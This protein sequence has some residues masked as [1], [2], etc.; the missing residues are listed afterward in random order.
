MFSQKMKRKPFLFN[1]SS[2]AAASKGRLV[3][4]RQK[5]WG[6]EKWE[7]EKKWKK[8]VSEATSTENEKGGS[9]YRCFRRLFVT[10]IMALK[11]LAK[12]F[13]C[14]HSGILLK[15]LS[16][17]RSYR[18]LIVLHTQPKSDEDWSNILFTQKVFW[19]YS[20]VASCGYLQQLTLGAK[21]DSC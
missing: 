10:G 13:C 11:K 2:S 9:C 15:F 8:V 17:F 4:K 12:D 1:K 20:H 16:F 6:R 7:A 14:S 21:I 19:G 5:S 3:K 18:V